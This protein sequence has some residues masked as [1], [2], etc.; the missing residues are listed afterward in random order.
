MNQASVEHFTAVT[1]LT[2]VKSEQ[3]RILFSAI[4]S[5]L[6]AILICSSLISIAQWHV[7]DH[8][9]IIA[10]F[11]ITNLLS[12]LRILMFQPFER[13]QRERLVDSIWA[14][15]AVL[16]SI[17]S[18]ITWGVGGYLLYPEQSPVQE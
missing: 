1:E 2:D 11:S 14:E 6:V 18:G 17:A 15:R 10:W 9:T 7:I 8:D 16:T 13:Q 5:S 3:I 4:P 12:L